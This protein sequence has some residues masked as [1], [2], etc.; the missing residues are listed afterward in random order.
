MQDQIVHP[1]YSITLAGALLIFLGGAILSNPGDVTLFLVRLSGFA[2]ATA[3]I[4]LFI[5]CLMQASSM[6]AIPFEELLLAGFLLMFGVALF[7]FAGS[8][9]KMIFSLFGVL[10]ILSGL[11]DILR[12]RKMTAEYD[13]VQRTT[14]RVGLVTIAAGIFVTIIPTVSYHV[15]PIICGVTLVID[16]LSELFIALRIEG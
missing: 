2:C 1:R 5:G 7:M 9:T 4:V 8:F 13:Q 6:D 14:L 3:G 15:V 16:G 12:A 10:I 11:G